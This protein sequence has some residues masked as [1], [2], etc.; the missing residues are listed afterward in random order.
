[1][2]NPRRTEH[3]LGTAPEHR[4][5][6]AP[7]S[8]S[9]RAPIDR[10]SLVRSA[11][12]RDFQGLRGG[13]SV[14]IGAFDRQVHP[15]TSTVSADPPGWACPCRPPATSSTS[16]PSPRATAA[17]R[18]S[19]DVTLGVAAG[20]RIGVVGAQRR[21][22]VDAAAADRRASRQPDA[23]TLTRAGDVRARAARP[24]RRARRAA[25]RSAR[26]WSASRAEHEWA[27][28]S[29][30]PRRARRAARRRRAARASRDGLD[31]PIAG[32]VRRRA[33]ADRARARCCSTA[34]SCCCSTSRPTT[35]TS[36]ASTGW[37][38]T[39]PRA[40][41]SLLVVTHDRWFLDAVCTADLGG[42]RRRGPPVRRRLRGVRARARRARPPGGRARGPPPRSCC[43]R[44]S[45]GCAAGRRRARPSRSSA[46]TP[47]TR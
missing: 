32:A 3:S 44:S 36:R 34:P 16:R 15:N 45:R 29:A 13:S 46:S 7:R 10:F 26:S 37:P 38:A 22:Q 33:P 28:D 24:G 47:P 8:D 17:A 18:C 5:A 9:S 4:A 19:R 42:R 21:R 14:R 23:G 2:R 6:R 25:R 30:L 11:A 43:A 39:S 31:T 12:D 41:G 35:S 1:M 40:R 20:D 27:G